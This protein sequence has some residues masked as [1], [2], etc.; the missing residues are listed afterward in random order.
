[1]SP[2]RLVLVDGSALVFRAFYALPQSLRTAAGVPTNAVYGFATALREATAG[3][4]TTHAA[5]VFDAPGPTFRQQIDASYKANRPRPPN[6]LTSQFPLARRV[7]EAFGFA[8]LEV[9][10]VE[11][12]DVIGTLARQAESQGIQV[13]IVSSD[14]D[15]CQL[16]S[17]GIQLLEPL[18]EVTRDAE[19]VR[20]RWGVR[21][22]QFADLLALMGDSIDNIPGVP[23]IGA[24]GAAKLL[25]EHGSLSGLIEAKQTLTGRYARALQEHATQAERSL[26]LAT[27]RTDVELAVGLPELVRADAGDAARVALFQELEFFSLLDQAPE[28]VTAEHPVELLESAEQARDFFSRQQPSGWGLSVVTDGVS[29]VRGTTLGLA[30]AGDDVAY[31]DLQTDSEAVAVVRAWLQDEQVAKAVCTVRDALS[32]LHRVGLDL[33]GVDGDPSLASFLLDPTAHMPHGHEQVVRAALKRPATSLRPLVPRGGTL[34]DV[35]KTELAATAGAMAREVW[36]SWDVLEPQ[37]R[38]RGLYDLLVEHELPL[39]WVLARMQ[40]GGI[41]VDVERLQGLQREFSSRRDAVLNELHAMAGRPFNPGST[42]Q[43][44]M[45]L[46]DELQLPVIKRTKTGYSTDASVMQ[47]LASQ[48]PIAEAVLRWRALAKL[49]NTYT[50]VLLDAAAQ[51]GRVHATTTQTHS[52]SGRLICTEP[53]LQRTPIRTP[54]GQ[55]IRE[56]FIPRAGWVLISADY[57]QIELRLLAHMSGDPALTQ[58]FAD[59]RD[60]H[61]ATAARVFDVAPGEVSPEQ[62]RVGKTVNFATLYGQGANSLAEQLSL[63]RSE[64]KALI[65]RYFERFRGVREWMV[66]TVQATRESGWCKTLLGRRRRVHEITSKN[67]QTRAYGER[68]AVNTPIQGSAADLCKRAML[69]IDE[70]LYRDEFQARMVLQIH[71][72][73]LFEAPPEEAERLMLRVKTLMEAVYPLRVPLVVDV[74]CGEN[75]LLAH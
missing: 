32:A 11:A 39:S 54:D 13:L 55:R 50:Q 25:N 59:G 64:A 5:V 48:H 56:A 14:K 41:G 67:P 22:D 35:P 43:L 34:T 1:M 38:E 71:D 29:A 68:I 10:G 46:F 42:Q 26:A 49:V 27:I 45:V 30:I 21:P 57:S 17:P 4:P 61:L 23:G 2:R 72:E 19:W 7:A 62:R 70:A 37:L 6:E 40:D 47:K 24:K 8:V 9:A 28:P 31:V 58:A 53:D 18:R 52:V 16:V 33:G 74:G 75:W 44:S 15:F 63:S 51:D 3:R 20:K 73:L 66:G 65:T 69:R 36:A 12:D 60:V